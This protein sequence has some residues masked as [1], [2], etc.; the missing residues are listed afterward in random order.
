MLPSNSQHGSIHNEDQDG[1]DVRLLSVN[2]TRLVV[3]QIQGVADQQGW[4]PQELVPPMHGI[5]DDI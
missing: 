2:A 3:I 1:D 4:C 5:F